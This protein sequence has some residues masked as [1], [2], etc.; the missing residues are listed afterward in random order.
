MLLTVLVAVVTVV[1]CGGGQGEPG[2][3]P[4][5]GQGEPGSGLGGGPGSGPGQGGSGEGEGEGFNGTDIAWIQLMI[6]M[7]EQVLPLLDLTTGELRTPAMTVRAGHVEELTRLKALRK[8]A[9]L[10]EV[11]LHAGHVMPGLVTEDDLRASATDKTR[12]VSEVIE[13]LEQRI[14]LAKGVSSSGTSKG[15]KS[16]AQ[17]IEQGSIDALASWRALSMEWVPSVHPSKEI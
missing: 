16:L 6:A 17:A 10:S 9:G 3:G 2:G 14:L 15:V 13:H 4:G 5:G 7:N 12:L 1:A 11:N 8:Q